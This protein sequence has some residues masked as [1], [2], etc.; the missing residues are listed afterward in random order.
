LEAADVCAAALQ[1]LG[2]V[3]KQLAW[4]HGLGMVH[5][6]LNYDNIV[7]INGFWVTVDWHMMAEEGSERELPEFSHLLHPDQLKLLNEGAKTEI[8]SAASDMHALAVM[9]FEGTTKRRAFADCDI[10]LVC[11]WPGF[12]HAS[13]ENSHRVGQ[14]IL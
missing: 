12:M 3:S 10:S 2:H 1:M 7:F 5:R 8:V 11:F 9:L 4:L 14:V 13:D 6:N